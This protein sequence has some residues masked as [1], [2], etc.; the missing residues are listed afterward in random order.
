MRN[1]LHS[2]YQT[3]E[4]DRFEVQLTLYFENNEKPTKEHNKRTWRCYKPTRP[5]VDNIAKFYLDAGNGILWCDDDQVVKLSV[6]KQFDDVP[7]T[8]IKVIQERPRNVMQDEAIMGIFSK[9]DA[10]TLDLFLQ[11]FKDA[12]AQHDY[13]PSENSIYEVLSLLKEYTLGIGK[14]I[15]KIEKELT[16]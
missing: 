9:Q 6:T 8:I 4:S 14:K 3:H 5:D 2:D 1:T 12:L 10:R 13:E 16:R 7:R 11:Q 15:Q